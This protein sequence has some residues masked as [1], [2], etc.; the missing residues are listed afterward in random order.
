LK[1]RRTSTLA[2]LNDYQENLLLLAEM[3]LSDNSDFQHSETGFHSSGKYYDVSWPVADEKDAEFFRPNQGYGKQLIDVALHEGKDLSTLPVCQKLH[4]I[5]QPKTGQ[6]ADVKLLCQRSGQLLLAKVSIG[7]QEQQ[8]EQLLVAAVTE[9]GE[10]VAEETASRLLRL[11]LSEVTSI[12]EQPLL[13]TL[14]AQC[15]VLRDS[16]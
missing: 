13:P 14:T 10:V 7:N 3:F 11:P 12:E 16:F 6:L 8:R 1:T 2:Q 9:N 15:E 5:Y 4:F